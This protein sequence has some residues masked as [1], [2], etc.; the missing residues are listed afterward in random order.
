MDLLISSPFKITF[1]VPSVVHVLEKWL[2][3]KEGAHC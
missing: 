3:G 1:L 2:A